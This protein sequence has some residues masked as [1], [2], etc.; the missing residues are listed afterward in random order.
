[1][2]VSRSDMIRN[3]MT[4]VRNANTAVVWRRTWIPFATLLRSGNDPLI[5][6]GDLAGPQ[7]R[8]IHC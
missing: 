8:P 4:K 1:M 5:G 7:I 6:G 2:T 3:I